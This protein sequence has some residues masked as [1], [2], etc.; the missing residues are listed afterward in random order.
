[1]SDVTRKMINLLDKVVSIERV[2]TNHYHAN[3]DNGFT[4]D[5]KLVIK[6]YRVEL[7]LLMNNRN[8][9]TGNA[10]TEDT[11]KVFENVRNL[12]YQLTCKKQDETMNKNSNLWSEL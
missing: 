4:I 2:T 1:M 7:D 6:N 3:L 12:H 9:Y 10:L 5:F 8:F 11:I